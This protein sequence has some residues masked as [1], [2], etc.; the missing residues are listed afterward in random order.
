MRRVFGVK[1]VSCQ[2]RQVDAGDRHVNVVITAMLLLVAAAFGPFKKKTPEPEP[3]PAVLSSIVTK[4]GEML[5]GFFEYGFVWRFA[6]LVFLN[7]KFRLM[8]K[9]KKG[10]KDEYALLLYFAFWLA[11]IFVLNDLPTCVVPQVH[12]QHQ[13]QRI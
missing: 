11:A 7:T 10:I 2:N 4:I 5:L 3:A 6:V 9:L 12:W 1:I 8:E 13:I